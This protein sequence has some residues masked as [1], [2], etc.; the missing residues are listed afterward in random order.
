MVTPSKRTVTMELRAIRQQMLESPP[1]PPSG[2]G[3]R[4]WFAGLALMNPELMKIVAPE[5]RAV[6]AVRLADELISALAV[7]PMPS[8]ASVANPSETEL[9]AWSKALSDKKSVT[10][11]QQAATVPPPKAL[12]RSPSRG[13]FSRS[14]L[15]P[16]MH[17]DEPS[18]V[19][20][21]RTATNVLKQS[22]VGTLPPMRNKCGS[23]SQ[24][25]PE[26]GV[27][28]DTVTVK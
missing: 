24:I 20:H 1:P 15:P 23:Y 5:A 22:E 14:M 11:A 2:A 13:D 17:A 7:A 4:E 8:A 10:E 6:E 27:S 28:V 16:P 12:K 21:F 19:D 18:A 26:V 25:D 9:A 3:I